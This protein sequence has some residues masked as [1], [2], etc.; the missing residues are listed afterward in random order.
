MAHL[1]VVDDDVA[2]TKLLKTLLEL[3][4]FTVETAARGSDALRM[5]ESSS[6]ALFLLDYQLPDVE[7]VELVQKLREM[8]QFAHTPIVVVSGRYV[9]PEVM[10]A[11]ATAFML[12][13][14]DTAELTVL[15]RQ[16]IEG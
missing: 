11:G 12:K 10:A 7:G 16:L 4:G 9:E 13:P 8:P 15:M 2:M 5:A 3:D 1:L 14:Y 6:P